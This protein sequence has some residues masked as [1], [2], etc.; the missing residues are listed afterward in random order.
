VYAACSLVS[1][2]NNS[3]K[4][5]RAVV[6]RNDGSLPSDPKVKIIEADVL[7]DSSK[8]DE[9][10]TGATHII[11]AAAGTSKETCIQVDNLGYGAI[12]GFCTISYL[13]SHTHTTETVGCCTM[14]AFLRSHNLKTKGFSKSL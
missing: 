12:I 11:Y 14:G 9:V 7:G 4:E 1:Q 8:M 13:F 2:Y 5:V 10:L 3:I 6:R